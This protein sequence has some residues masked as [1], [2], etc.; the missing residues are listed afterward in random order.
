MTI[1]NAIYRIRQIKPN[2][3][4]DDQLVEWLSNLDKQVWDEVVYWHESDMPEPPTYTMDDLSVQL[5]IPE[6][7]SDVYVKYL[8]MEIDF[9]NN[10]ITRYNNSSV[11]F[12]KALSNYADWFN[13]RHLPKQ[14]VY[15]VI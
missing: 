1:E 4:P 7:F 3:Y 11:A 12:G 5:L 8:C 13:R 14:S 10:E 9:Y 6:P 15:V 2:E